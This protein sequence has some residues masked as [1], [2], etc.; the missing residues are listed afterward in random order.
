MILY[1]YYERIID[2]LVCNLHTTT[3]PRNS[4]RRSSDYIIIIIMIRARIL[5]IS[6]I[7]HCVCVYELVVCYMHIINAYILV[8]SCMI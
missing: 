4:I 6:N 5:A 1:I 7:Y 2:E 8:L 3:L